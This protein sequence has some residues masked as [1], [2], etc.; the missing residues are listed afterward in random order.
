MLKKTKVKETRGRKPIGK[1]NKAI[2][3]PGPYF[4]P[5]EIK[6]L[7]GKSSVKDQMDAFAK[8]L[9]EKVSL[10]NPDNK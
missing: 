5:A 10:E 1:S 2:Q 9:K 7:G 3:I 6:A 8:F 4:T